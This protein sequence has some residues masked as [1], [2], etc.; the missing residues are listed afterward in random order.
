[1]RYDETRH[2]LRSLANAVVAI[3][4]RD[5]QT[6]DKE[7]LHDIL[8]VASQWGFISIGEYEHGRYEK[9]AW[10][11]QFGVSYSTT[12]DADVFTIESCGPNG[13]SEAGEGDD[14]FVRIVFKDNARPEITEG[15]HPNSP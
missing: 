8:S 15:G 2:S 11:N 9:D 6:L 12:H 3:H 14:M 5:P 4:E 13:I 10:G 1:M 7:Q